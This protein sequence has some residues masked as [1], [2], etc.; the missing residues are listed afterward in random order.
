MSFK[1]QSIHRWN[2][3]SCSLYYYFLISQYTMAVPVLSITLTNN[4][5]SQLN[6]VNFYFSRCFITSSDRLIN[7]YFLRLL[8]AGWVFNNFYLNDW[9]VITSLSLDCL[10]FFYFFGLLDRSYIFKLDTFPLGLL[11]EVFDVLT[12]QVI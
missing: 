9:Q 5:Y 1:A 8:F 11:D 4:F 2:M 3:L 10:V 7:A 6:L 12:C